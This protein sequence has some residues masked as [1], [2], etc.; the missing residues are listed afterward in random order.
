MLGKE[1][2]DVM[3]T[4]SEIDVQCNKI[5][6]MLCDSQYKNHIDIEKA[7]GIKRAA[8]YRR[9]KQI[10]EEDKKESLTKREVRENSL[11]S[12]SLTRITNAL[13][14]VSNIS[15]E[16]MNNQ[17]NKPRDR[18]L[19]CQLNLTTEIWIYQNSMYGSGKTNDNIKQINLS[20]VFDIKPKSLNLENTF[21]IGD[22][23]DK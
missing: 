17:K 14:N 10:Q 4:N 6:T 1:V 23:F 5:R 20:K 19:A 16:M 13:E 8:Y 22:A 2:I 12:D 3:V 21:E 11:T 15:Y 18:I 7:L 9:L